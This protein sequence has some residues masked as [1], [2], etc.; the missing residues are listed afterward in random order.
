M[1][2]PSFLGRRGTAN[3]QQWMF[4][5][6]ELQELELWDD[7]IDPTDLLGIGNPLSPD[8]SVPFLPLVNSQ[9]SLVRL[10]AAS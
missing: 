2:T 5:W 4:A 7:F 9:T 8:S 3:N 6:A 10:L 1:T